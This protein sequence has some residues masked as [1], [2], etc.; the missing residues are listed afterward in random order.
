MQEPSSP[1]NFRAQQLGY[2]DVLPSRLESNPDAFGPK[3]ESLGDALKSFNQKMVLGEDDISGE[4]SFYKLFTRK[5]SSFVWN[6]FDLIFPVK[7]LCLSLQ[8]Q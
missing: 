7:Y 4:L 3:Y 5:S 8:L 6:A 2:K 1:G